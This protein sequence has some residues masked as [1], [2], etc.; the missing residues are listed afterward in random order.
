M[1]SEARQKGCP[2]RQ[3]PPAPV[4]EHAAGGMHARRR[5]QAA[6]RFHACIGESG[7]RQEWKGV[8]VR[9]LRVCGGAACS[10]ARRGEHACAARSA[11]RE[12]EKKAA[13]RR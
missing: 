3:L 10:S 12:E 6:L 11:L 7:A 9:M 1:Q 13:G 2:S 5:R 4:R 8:E